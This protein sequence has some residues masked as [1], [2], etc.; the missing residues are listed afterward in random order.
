[1]VRIQPELSGNLSNTLEF[2]EMGCGTLSKMHSG[3]RRVQDK[4]I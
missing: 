3:G 1:M 4:L 2:E